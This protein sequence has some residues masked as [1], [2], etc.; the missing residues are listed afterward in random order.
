MEFSFTV[1]L[2]QRTW[3]MASDTSSRYFP[4]GRIFLKDS[5]IIAK[6]KTARKH[7]LA[8]S[9][10]SLPLV[11]QSTA[12]RTVVSDLPAAHFGFLLLLS[13]ADDHSRPAYPGCT[14]V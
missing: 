12:P 9:D 10:K 4:A 1:G 14:Q 13:Q 6:N 7:N 8:G 5:T 3:Y 2:W 11:R